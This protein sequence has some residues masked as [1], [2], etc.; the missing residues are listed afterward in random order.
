MGGFDTYLMTAT[1]ITDD[2]PLIKRDEVV[3]MSTRLFDAG[4]GRLI[5][6]SNTE[7]VNPGRG[8]REIAAFTT[9]ILNALHKEKFI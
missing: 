5:W 7:T 8:A 3:T 4:T 9:I 2:S 6:F 1:P